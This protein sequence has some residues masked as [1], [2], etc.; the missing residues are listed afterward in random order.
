MSSHLEDTS[1]SF[2]NVDIC[3]TC[4]A[5]FFT[6]KYPNIGGIL[7]KKMITELGF[8]MFLFAFK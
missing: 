4:S 5:C 2:V 7:C 8:F 1:K 6:L 3:H